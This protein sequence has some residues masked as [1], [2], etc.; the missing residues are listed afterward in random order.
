[1]YAKPFLA[2]MLLA[3]LPLLAASRCY[4][5]SLLPSGYFAQAAVLGGRDWAA[6]AGVVWS[7]PW[8]A[9][10][11]GHP[12]TTLGEASINHWQ[13]RGT[14]HSNGF[15]HVALVPL[16]RMR[17]DDGRSPWFAEAGI[18]VSLT[19]QLFSTQTKKFTTRFNFVDTAGVGRSLGADRRQDLSVRLQH[20]S[21][22]GIRVPNPGQ[23]FLQLRYAAAF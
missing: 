9:R 6:G 13:A 17:F 4:A 16:A 8:Q 14:V 19:D 21:N 23:N 10:F 15:T 11:L 20:V 1:M 3:A 18:G 5:Q 12:V 2:S 22:A 7:L